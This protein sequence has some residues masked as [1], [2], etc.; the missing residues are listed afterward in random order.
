MDV[1]RGATATAKA[2]AALGKVGTGRGDEENAHPVTLE[3]QQQQQKG[4]GRRG[5]VRGAAQV[6][7]E[8]QKGE[9][10]QVGEEA[11]EG[12]L[13]AQAENGGMVEKGASENE[14]REGGG[15]GMLVGGELEKQANRNARKENCT[16]GK[17]RAFTLSNGGPALKVYK[18]R[19]RVVGG[20]AVAVKIEEEV[21]GGEVA[22]AEGDDVATNSE[23]ARDEAV[24][25]DVA[26]ATIMAGGE[27]AGMVSAVGVEREEGEVDSDEG[28]GE[29]LE[30][31]DMAGD[32][33]PRGN[34]AGVEVA[35]DE[36]A[37]D[38]M[39]S[40]KVAVAGVA[41]CVSQTDGAGRERQLLCLDVIVSVQ[42]AVEVGVK[43]RLEERL[44]EMEERVREE[45]RKRVREDEKMKRRELEKRLA[46]ATKRVRRREKELSGAVRL[47]A[48]LE[49]R[50]RE[51]EERVREEE[52]TKM[53]DVERKASEGIL[54][55]EGREEE[56]EE[57]LKACDIVKTGLKE[58]LKEIEARVKEAEREGIEAAEGSQKREEVLKRAVEEGAK[59]VGAL[60]ARVETLERRVREEE[61]NAMI[62]VERAKKRE[63]E[64]VSALE[65]AKS[66][67]AG[68]EERL[69]WTEERVREEEASRKM[70]E[71][72]RLIEAMDRM[73]RQEEE[74]KGAVEERERVIAGLRETLREMEERVRE[75]RARKRRV[76]EMA[77]EASQNAERREE[78][79]TRK[80]K[81]SE[82]V[83]AELRGRLREAEAKRIR[84]EVKTAEALD[85]AKRREEEL[86]G[87][88]RETERVVAELREQHREMEDRA[89]KEK[90]R[91]AGVV[92]DLTRAVG[93]AWGREEELRGMV[94][95]A[96]KAVSEVEGCVEEKV[97][98]V[99][100][101]ARLVRAK[102]QN[103]AHLPDTEWLALSRMGDGSASQNLMEHLEV[104][105][106]HLEAVREKAREARRRVQGLGGASALA[107]EEAQV[108][109]A[110]GREEEEEYEEQ[111]S[112]VPHSEPRCP[113]VGPTAAG[114]SQ[115]ATL[116]E[117]NHGNAREKL[118]DGGGGESKVGGAGGG[119][120]G[121]FGVAGGEVGNEVVARGDQ[122]GRGAGEQGAGVGQ[123]DEVQSGHRFGE[124][125]E[126]WR[127]MSK[128][129]RERRSMEKMGKLIDSLLRHISPAEQGSARIEIYE[130]VDFLSSQDP[131]ASLLTLTRS[132][133]ENHTPRNRTLHCFLTLAPAC[134]PGLLSS[135]SSLT[136]NGLSPIQLHALRSL[137]KLPALTSL[138]F[139]E[140]PVTRAAVPL[141]KSFTRLRRL[142][143]DCPDAHLFNLKVT[144]DSPEG[145]K[146]LGSLMELHM[147]GVDDE[148]LQ[149]VGLLQSLEAF[150]CT[151]REEV[152]LQGWQHL[153]R[154][155]KLRWL[156][157]APDWQFPEWDSSEGSGHS[158]A[159]ELEFSKDSLPKI[160]RYYDDSPSGSSGSSNSPRLDD[161]VWEVVGELRG[162][163]HLGVHAAECNKVAAIAL[164]KLR[165]LKTLH[166][167]TTCVDRF[168][169]GCLTTLHH[170][171]DLSLAGCKFGHAFVPRLVGVA[172][173]LE[174]LDLSGTAVTRED[175]VRLQQLRHLECLKLQQCRNLKVAFLRQLSQLPRL[176]TLDLS[177][178]SIQLGWLRPIV[179]KRRVTRL[180]VRECDFQL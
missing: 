34:L 53:S 157:V 41:T 69:Q 102:W 165:L 30:I 24:R 117:E 57:A 78:E 176:K 28:E 17:K 33:V 85:K 158:P 18:R 154:L 81:E 58:R 110:G 166:V 151:C 1:G 114:S 9:E 5:D 177:F 167:T 179:D 101:A 74:L 12:G 67:T 113:G 125:K 35:R 122:G 103:M 94:K 138:T 27:V 149:E 108:A 130:V 20:G 172:P 23:A 32:K 90:A 59:L 76:E 50:L 106:L 22:G 111:A 83:V 54:G 25:N 61:E 71:E 159:L 37:A 19:G 169:T 72:K 40:D 109:D 173:K 142:V 178:N 170:L 3:K 56:L 70:E 145:A 127:N 137:A 105:P 48:G 42:R 96:E 16:S 49:E 118:S 134:C 155:T 180:L 146:P 126:N 139:Q 31:D 99:L 51:A 45:E 64:I 132:T 95:E 116:D 107:G 140:T 26:G 88:V 152:T 2:N 66:V 38:E 168:D 97:G 164:R 80:V 55:A 43:A 4:L 39:V 15:G 121:G 11:Q 120:G 91:N 7:G 147:S 73:K 174:S 128:E 10:A 129:E 8:A 89:R 153:K 87:A 82:R 62:A 65:E 156:Q 119:E 143:L 77:S 162:L 75:E 60:K 52:E 29:E 14:E 86:T 6:M 131:T 13:E 141:L 161:G 21:A 136:L 104:L 163:E 160:I 123:R 79:S 44:G 98:K 100:D 112:N 124:S 68:L 175:S 135:L 63:A 150:S 92:A 47:M 36:V 133:G 46:G 115:G 171:T 84:Q 93:K 144:D 148:N